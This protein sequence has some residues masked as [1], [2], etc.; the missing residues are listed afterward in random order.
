[1]AFKIDNNIVVLLQKK[2]I[3]PND[4]TKIYENA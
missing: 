1:M 2:G 3:I 4:G